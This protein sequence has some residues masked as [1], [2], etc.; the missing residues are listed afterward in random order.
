MATSATPSIPIVD[1]HHHIW[2][3]SHTAWLQGPELPRIFGPYAPL[4]RDYPI[5]EFLADCTPS[6]VL[7]SVFVQVNVA[8]GAEVDETEWVASVAART[9]WPHAITAFADLSSPDVERTL[10]RELA[11]GLVRAIRQQLHWHEQ[12]AYRFASRPDVADDPQ[13]RRG[14]AAVARHGLAFELQVFPGQ[15]DVALRLVRDFPDLTFVLI[16]AGMLEDRSDAG[17]QQWRRGVGLLAACPNVVTKLSGLGTFLRGCDEAAWR[18]VIRETIDAFGP[19]R[20]MFGSNFPIEKL[21]TD[22]GTL[23]AVFRRCIADLSAD[24]QAW[25]LHRSAARVYGIEI[26]PTLQE[27]ET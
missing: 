19:S 15:S 21:W 5:E 10:D 3:L 1:A 14:L 4:R 11:T 17:W 25:I 7:R 24:D 27:S 22:Y 6:G 2:R 9:G 16:H 13:W 26:P 20:C 12:A 18:P 8:P 23:T